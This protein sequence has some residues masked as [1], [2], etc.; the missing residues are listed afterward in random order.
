MALEQPTR[1]RTVDSEV[2][3]MD[4]SSG[5]AIVL[6]RTAVNAM[7]LVAAAVMIF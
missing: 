1:A 2:P 5:G 3:T 7:T 6:L 4:D